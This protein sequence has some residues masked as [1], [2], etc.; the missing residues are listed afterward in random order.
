MD[1]STLVFPANA[2]C[3]RRPDG[4]LEYALFNRQSHSYDLVWRTVIDGEE[5]YHAISIGREVAD[6]TSLDDMLEQRR[7]DAIKAFSGE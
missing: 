2:L 5:K 6:E 3:A 7:P 1:A 4:M